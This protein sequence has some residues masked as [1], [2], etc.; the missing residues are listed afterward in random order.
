MFDVKESDQILGRLVH[1]IYFSTSVMLINMREY[2]KTFVDF[3]R[4]CRLA[5]QCIGNGASAGE[6]DMPNCVCLIKRVSGAYNTA[7]STHW[8]GEPTYC[9]HNYEVSDKDIRYPKMNTGIYV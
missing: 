3:K 5:V 9:V 6:K 4:M 8:L 2:R 1:G 7:G